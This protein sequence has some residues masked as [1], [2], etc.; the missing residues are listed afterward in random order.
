MKKTLTAAI[1]VLMLTACGPTQQ[2][3]Q[4][5][6]PEGL[7]DCKFYLVNTNGN[8]TRVVRC[9]NSSTSTYHK[10]GKA[11][12]VDTNVIEDAAALKAQARAKAL[13]KLTPA[14]REVLG[15]Q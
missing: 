13:E 7:S 12:S 14:E 11:P 9:P 5:S 10:D 8:T 2:E 6:L 1:A 3:Y 4:A 15:L